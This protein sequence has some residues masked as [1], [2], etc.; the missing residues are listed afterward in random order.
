LIFLTLDPDG[1]VVL[2]KIA[3]QDKETEEAP[4]IYK[5]AETKS[6]LFCFSALVHE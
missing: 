1:E 4:V 3:E 5:R 6:L 2:E